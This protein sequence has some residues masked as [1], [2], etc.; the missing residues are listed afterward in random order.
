MNGSYN[1]GDVVLYNWKLVKLLG[2]GSYGKVY[3]AHREDLSG[4]YKAAIKIIVIPKS[5]DEISSAVTEGMTAEAV[6]DYFRGFVEELSAE[7]TLMS[8]LKGN[9]S[10]VSYEDH[11]AI[12]HTGGIGWDIIIRMELLTPLLEIIKNGSISK[13]SVIKLGLDMCD[14]LE[15][16]R[17]NK[18]I[19]RD[20]KPENIF[21]SETGDYK[22]G[23]FGI[24]RTIDRTMGGMS[25]KGTYT[26]MAPEVYREE[27]YGLTVDIYSL[28]IVMYRLLN[29]NRT[30]FLPPFPQ[31]IRHMDREKALARRIGGEQ[32]PPP[33]ND[34]GRL[35]KIVLKA[36]SYDPEERYQTAAEMKRDLQTL[37]TDTQQLEEWEEEDNN[38]VCSEPLPF[39]K[40]GTGTTTSS[41]EPEGIKKTKKS[42]K[43][44]IIAAAA[45]IL[46]AVGGLGFFMLNRT[47]RQPQQ[48]LSAVASSVP[49][50]TPAPTTSQTPIPAAM[51]TPTLTL[52]PAPSPTMVPALAQTPTPTPS[53]ALTATPTP[54][55]TSTPTPAPTPSPSPTP[56]LT[57]TP[58]PSPTP[59]PTP[60][61]HFW[62]EA[63]CLESAICAE[64]GETEGVPLGHDC[65]EA[66]C[67]E[68]K[69]C[70]RCGATEGKPLGH[71][72][73]VDVAVEPA[74]TTAG[75]TEGSHCTRCGEV[76]TEQETVKALG[77]DWAE[78]TCM[79]PKTCR[80]CGATVGKPLGH[81]ETTE[82][83]VEPGCITDG[84]TEGKYCS[85]CGEILLQ[86]Q[87]I[88]ALGHDWAEA[89]CTEPRTCMRCGV[90][91]GNPLGHAQ[92]VDAA[93]E[94]TCTE[95]GK[96]EG[97]HCSRCGE[98]LKEQEILKALG[99]D[100]L[101][102][103]CTE[104]K[105]CKLCGK[106]LG[107]ALGHTWTEATCTEAKTCRR[108]GTVEGKPLGHTET[109][110]A[111]IEP[112][113][114]ETGKTEGRYCSLC[115]AVLKEQEILKPLGHEWLEATCTE[116]K[117]C[118]R[119]GE[120]QGE[121]AGH[122]WIEATYELPETCSVCGATQGRPK[123]IPVGSYVCFGSYAQ[124][125]YEYSSEP[126]E[127]RV[128]SVQDGKA[129]L[130]SR[131][132]L[133]M[134][135]WHHTP[136]YVTWEECTLHNWL[137][138]TFFNTAFS[139]DEKEQIIPV[140]AS[141]DV[142]SIYTG[143]EDADK[144]FTLSAVE[145]DLYLPLESDRQCE[146]TQ[147]VIENGARVSSEGTCAWWLRGNIVNTDGRV[148][149]INTAYAENCVRPA[150]WV[151]LNAVTLAESDS[152][153]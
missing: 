116:P 84:L 128:L 119:C 83:A 12:P 137:N 66:T 106:T 56:T 152:G 41:I 47:N 95:T 131:Y 144:I 52:S 71:E 124:N 51:P 149:T 76:L 68:A 36:C 129:L 4:I 74:C 96:T 132:L 120:T 70:K 135:Q 82:E 112:T 59:T 65:E 15:L 30:P 20:I 104:P 55:P 118:S 22:L 101:E 77:H 122:R 140:T 35:S 105:T 141:K 138:E 3:E 63:T 93:V 75:K 13:E 29:N 38:T 42:G 97:S 34:N 81:L 107:K 61:A 127:W 21:C 99:H 147:Y 92:V 91:R 26:Y 87:N 27:P 98:E 24:A 85:R 16:C 43:Q 142:A 9:S 103:T 31:P 125:I 46:V 130:I 19:H 148:R 64:C 7:Y 88:T 57:P 80:R 10:I 48:P 67:T 32:I 25:K 18:I 102:A 89:T 58:M 17:K 133:D 108:C 136:S 1:I 115:G 151:N 50:Q 72:A 153:D 53:P 146:P 150:I 37:L 121:P 44:G 60:H 5:N 2:E 45:A 90:T 11:A 126:I 39:Y 94:P 23:D 8:K 33:V 6:S 111:S 139:A 69:I 123:E 117:K 40:T 86:Q 143:Y 134:Q 28:G 113:C 14:A 110:E 78:A 114:T 109:I 54:A 62:L 73:V 100:W 145:L 79:E 49:A